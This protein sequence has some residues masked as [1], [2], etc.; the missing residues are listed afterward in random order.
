[1]IARRIRNCRQCPSLKLLEEAQSMIDLGQDLFNLALEEDVCIKPENHEGRQDG[2]FESLEEMISEKLRL[3]NGLDYPKTNILLTNGI[4]SSLSLLLQTIL[5]PQ[6]EVIIPLPH[7]AGFPEIVQLVSGKAILVNLSPG[8]DYKLRP[9]DLKRAITKKTRAI[10]LTN[11]VNPTGMTYTIDEL[12]GLSEI[13]IEKKLIL[14]SDERGESF[15]YDGKNH[16]S[17]ASLNREIKNVSIVVS[18][19]S[20]CLTKR[21]S[22][23]S[24]L[25]ANETLIKEMKKIQ[26]YMVSGP[27]ESVKEET[28]MALRVRNQYIDK[29]L[30]F[31][32][33]QRQV[34]FNH[35]D[36]IE[37]LTY[38]KSQAS[39]YVLVD[40]SRLLA[41]K[42]HAVNSEISLGFC[43]AL[44]KR[45]HTLAMPGEVFGMPGT[46]RLCFA[47]SSL[48]EGFEKLIEFIEKY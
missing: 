35:L 6:D 44:L 12:L 22:N 36:R 37:G 8:D 34:M 18:D 28:L 42:Q 15:I 29:Q 20:A 30:E 24:Y 26:N 27:S 46:I 45:A 43:E 13:V 21:Q 47:V 39:F 3:D 41:K 32:K 48:E 1:M 17:I 31:L 25:A 10:I 7:P 14:I 16:I 33:N 38:L 5:N 9:A 2:G 19:F 11:P 40:I 4:Q 23:L